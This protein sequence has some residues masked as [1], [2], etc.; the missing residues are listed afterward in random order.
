MREKCWITHLTLYNFP[1]SVDKRENPNCTNNY[2]RVNQGHMKNLIFLP[3][4]GFELIRAS[5][6]NTKP[7]FFNNWVMFIHNMHIFIKRKKHDISFHKS[8]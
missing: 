4:V 1:K 6:Q 7:L 8:K 3:R 2:K 5:R